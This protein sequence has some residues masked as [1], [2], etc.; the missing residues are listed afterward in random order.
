MLQGPLEEDA[1]ANRIAFGDLN[2]DG[3]DD[4]VTWN[5]DGIR[6]RLNH[7]G[8]AYNDPIFVPGSRIAAGS[9]GWATDQDP[10][11]VRVSFADMN[12]NGINDLL[13]IIDGFVWAVDLARNDTH[14]GPIAPA[15]DDAPRGGLL[16]EIDNG[17]GAS[18]L[19]SYRSS[20]DLY[21]ES[22]RAEMP[23]SEPLPQVM[24]VVGRITAQTKVPSPY[25]V[26]QQV[27][28]TYRDPAW[29]GWRRR[30]LG[31]REVLTAEGDPAFGA[32]QALLSRSTYFIPA[33]P[34][35][36]CGS[37][38][39]TYTQQQVVSGAPLIS[40]T[41]D[42]Q[43]HYLSTV[44]RSYKVMQS[45]MALDGRAVQFSYVS[46]VD[47]RLYDQRN[48]TGFDG[49]APFTVEGREMKWTGL[50]PVRSRSNAL[51]RQTQTL[52]TDGRLIESIDHGHIKNDGGAIDNPIVRRATPAAL[53]PDWK[54]LVASVRIEPF[55]TRTQP[56]VPRTSR[57]NVVSTTTRRDDSQQR[58]F[59]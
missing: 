37:G 38:D 52:D 58:G 51:L 46:Q 14:A 45:M 32:S 27:S 11:K 42:A 48:W 41:F 36:Y 19:V 30:F 28:Y 15:D 35:G 44:S 39:S 59:T 1:A 26:R 6:I 43:G 33:C 54:F 56:A 57:V 9:A 5:H 4:L 16:V 53:R 29:D 2:G 21:R 8:W 50:A 23:W 40:E 47:T 3:L 20:A 24:M 25:G 22:E 31:F 12:G 17:L 55:P 7:E 34:E 13:V 10:D 49:V 18:T